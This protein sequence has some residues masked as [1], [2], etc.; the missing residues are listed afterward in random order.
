MGDVVVTPGETHLAVVH[1]VGV[2][3][4]ST[5]GAIPAKAFTVPWMAAIC[6]PW[7]TA[8]AEETATTT[9]SAPRPSVS[10]D[11]GDGVLRPRLHE[12]VGAE[13]ARRLQALR[14]GVAGDQAGPRARASWR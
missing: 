4:N 14:E 12:V 1:Q 3:G 2:E 6:S 9:A 13:G 8:S 10:L 7:R 11:P 5:A